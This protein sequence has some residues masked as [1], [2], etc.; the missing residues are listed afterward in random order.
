[1]RRIRAPDQ[2]GLSISIDASNGSIGF[3]E[4]CLGSIERIPHE[5]TKALL[6]IA[7]IFLIKRV[8]KRD[9]EERIALR[10]KIVMPRRG[11]DSDGNV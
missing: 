9:T 6:F 7:W 3:F 2:A 8:K 4:C 10:Q 1:M 5:L 11:K